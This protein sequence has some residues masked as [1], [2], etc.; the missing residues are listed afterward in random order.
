MLS[1]IILMPNYF[2]ALIIDNNLKNNY[3]VAFELI[4]TI[5]KKF[6]GFKEN[7]SVDY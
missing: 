3:A 2:L 6:S 5:G 4:I 7:V 1:L